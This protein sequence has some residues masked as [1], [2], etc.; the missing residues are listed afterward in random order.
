MTELLADDDRD[1]DGRFAVLD[2]REVFRGGI[3]SV[4]RDTVTMPGGGSARRDVVEHLRAVAVVAID[5]DGAVVLIEQY[6][7]PLRRR[8]WEIP[9]GLMDVGGESAQ[10]AARRELAEEVGLAADTWSVLV[11]LASSPGFCTEAVRV[12]LATDLHPTVA[13]APV[14]EEADMRQIRLPLPDAVAAVLRRDIVNGTTVA[15]LLA[16]SQVVS[17]AAVRSAASGGSAALDGHSSASGG[18]ADA[19]DW[20]ESQALINR[21]ETIGRAPSLAV[22]G[23]R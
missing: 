4:R 23:G 11:D 17:G 2:S 6:R 13:E 14:D 19:G 8:L 1:G 20:T 10:G 5:A 9:A 16:A 15:G 21:R 18:S 3:F 22:P 7:H 12:F